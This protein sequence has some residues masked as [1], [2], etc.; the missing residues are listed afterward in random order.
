M[1]HHYLKVHPEPFHALVSGRKTAE[2]RVN[3]RDYKCGDTVTLREY[4][5]EEDSYTD[6]FVYTTITHIQEGYGLPVGIVV[7]SYA[8]VE[9]NT[10]NRKPNEDLC[11]PGRMRCAKCALITS[12]GYSANP[13]NCPNGCGP[14]WPVTWKELAFELSDTNKT[15]EEDYLRVNRITKWLEAGCLDMGFEIDGGVYIETAIIGTGTR[16]LRGQADV[17]TALDKMHEELSRG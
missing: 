16:M 9:A 14:M 2:V 11:V 3:D 10:V 5:P 17:R 12:G 15:L 1:K 7:L 4:V 13:S 6:N 8:P